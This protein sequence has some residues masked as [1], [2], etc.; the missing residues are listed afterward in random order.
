MILTNAHTCRSFS[1]QHSAV[2]SMEP[3]SEK[4]DATLQQPPLYDDYVA[5]YKYLDRWYVAK[6]TRV[7]ERDTFELTFM[8]PTSSRPWPQWYW[9]DRRDIQEV[10]SEDIIMSLMTIPAPGTKRRSWYHTLD[11]DIEDQ[12]EQAFNT[13]P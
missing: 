5:A 10:S 12:V 7:L 9:P 6:V 2:P 13:M 8:E 11:Q 1:L 4:V 3:Q